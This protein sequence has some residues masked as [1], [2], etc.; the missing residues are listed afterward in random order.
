MRDD[1]PAVHCFADVA[2][3]CHKSDILNVVLI[4]PQNAALSEAELCAGVDKSQCRVADLNQKR[5]GE[6]GVAGWYDMNNA[7]TF[8]H[9][10]LQARLCPRLQPCCH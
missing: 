9:R 6:R 3:L 2:S 5:L 7:F 8:R 4:K 1:T 10:A